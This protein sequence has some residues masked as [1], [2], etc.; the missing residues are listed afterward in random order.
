MRDLEPFVHAASK[1]ICGFVEDHAQLYPLIEDVFRS[2]SA[3]DHKRAVKAQCKVA[4]EQY[5]AV[6]HLVAAD[7][8]LPAH[9][10][11]RN[12]FEVMLSTLYLARDESRYD[13]FLRFG[14]KI[15]YELVR[16]VDSR[17]AALHSWVPEELDVRKLDYDGLVAH[18]GKS[19]NWSKK[20][21]ADL[22]PII[23]YEQLYKTFYKESSSIA[24]GNSFVLLKRNH[25]HAWEIQAEE[26]T[27]HKYTELAGRFSYLTVA[28]LFVD[29][30]ETLGFGHTEDCHQLKDH[31]ARH[32]EYALP[33]GF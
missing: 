11:C 1:Y 28:H 33:P 29:V 23:G 25:F 3:T 4:L 5:A 30:D 13:D 16:N 24:H 9:G 26:K 32:H 6:L 21:V 10:L 18:F 20:S 27:W 17:V 22:A 12:L 19:N 8:G 14:T 2:H 31:I 15:H 7:L